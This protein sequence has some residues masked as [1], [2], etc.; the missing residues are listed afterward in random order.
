LNELTLPEMALIAGLPQAPS[1][2][3]PYNNIDLAKKRRNQVLGRMY[4]MKYIDKKTYEEAKKAEIVLS[5]MPRMYATNKAPYFCD[6]VIK[7]LQKLGFTEEDIVISFVAVY[8]K[9]MIR[10]NSDY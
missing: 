8:T 6:Y 10:A 1:V 2:Y 5:T 4:K 7:D 9:N 3:S